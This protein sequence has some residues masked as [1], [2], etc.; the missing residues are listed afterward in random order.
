MTT[1]KQ[2]QNG[3]QLSLDLLIARAV[4]DPALRSELISDAYA[5]CKANKVDV[6]ISVRLVVTDS[7]TNTIVR[8]IPR[9]TSTASYKKTQGKFPTKEPAIY[10]AEDV[11]LEVEV[12]SVESLQ[13]EMDITLQMYGPLEAMV[14][15]TE[16]ANVVVS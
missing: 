5:C 4:L 15:V 3:W 11:A 8:E 16:G 6:P 9:L 2:E 14:T 7:E 1:S 13:A 12:E 10:N